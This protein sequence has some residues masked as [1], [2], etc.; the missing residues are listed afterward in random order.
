MVE[1]DPFQPGAQ[2][3][4]FRVLLN[5]VQIGIPVPVRLSAVTSLSS[6]AK[7]STDMVGAGQQQ[8]GA[9]EHEEVVV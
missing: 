4:S 2:F 1:S 3:T 5:A 9:T 7:F 8:P 6:A